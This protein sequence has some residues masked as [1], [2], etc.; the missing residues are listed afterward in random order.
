MLIVDCSALGCASKSV[1]TNLLNFVG[2]F[3]NAVLVHH[4]LL[5]DA[6]HQLQV[7]QNQPLSADLLLFL[8]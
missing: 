7:V 2:R 5:L 3:L 4:V 8:G 6:Q 1:P